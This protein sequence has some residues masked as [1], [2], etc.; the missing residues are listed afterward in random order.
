MNKLLFI[1]SICLC[2]IYPLNNA[3]QT[4]F[5]SQ[6]TFSGYEI[7]G[8]GA[9]CWFADPRIL[10][11]E[12][13]DGSI[14]KTYIGY[15][16]IHGN[17]KATQIDYRSNT[18]EEVLIRSW[19]QPD[20]HNNPTFL[21]LPDERI[22]V[23]YSRHTDEACFYY[24]VSRLPGDI[25]TLGQEKIIRTKNNTTYPSA[26]ILTNDPKHIYLCWRGI[27]WHPTIGRLLIPDDKGNTNFDWGPYQIVQSTG[28]RPYAKYASDGK[29]RIFMAY[30]TGHPDNEMPNHVYFNYIDINTLEL[31]DITGNVLSV[32]QE[33][34]HKVN[35]KPEYAQA[36]PTAV[37]SNSKY[38]NWLWEVA[39]DSTGNPV[40]AMTRISPDK[41]KHD[42]YYT[43]WTGN[44]WKSTF[45]AHGGGHFH[46]TPGLEKCY[47]GGITINKQH[48]DKV[49][50]SIP[51][52]G[53]Y[54]K[55]YELIECTIKANGQVTKRNITVNSRQNNVRPYFTQGITSKD[56]ASLYWMS[57]EYYDWIVSSSHPK[58]YCTRICCIAPLPLQ[59]VNLGNNLIEIKSQE[60]ITDKTD[61][62]IHKSVLKKN[63]IK[64]F[65]IALQCHIIPDSKHNTIV[66][67]NCITY[68][69]DANS[70]K[71][72]IIAQGSIF[73]SSNVLGNSDNWQHAPRSTNGKWMTPQDLS[74]FSLILT[75]K[76]GILRTYINGLLDQYIPLEGLT[77]KELTLGTFKGHLNNYI[78]YKRNLSQTEVKELHNQMQATSGAT[79]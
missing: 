71:P 38:R 46:Q 67:T 31:K 27:G 60:K 2:C 70:R 44:S 32:I 33:N 25:T 23:F 78:I 4:N 22:M 66:Q 62:Y 68:N 58:A 5:M 63:N 26:F 75:Y 21:V 36:H 3:A 17:I 73:Q 47:S 13:K 28:A 45:L 34:T 39:T 29:N 9:W 51:I 53:K 77:L 20:D 74:A 72:Y 6:P 79:N 64:S 43:K 42:Y 76:N 19:F 56:H 41:S 7:S 57:G 24:R 65:T 52:E 55:V 1:L 30:T 40:I 18:T 37:V 49:V 12:N 10:H 15:I 35:K 16:D 50:C 54:G 8:E 61:S 14:N 48:P 69:L 11:Y 59:P